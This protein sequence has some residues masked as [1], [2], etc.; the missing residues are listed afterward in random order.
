MIEFTN[1]NLLLSFLF[2]EGHFLL[3]VVGKSLV[4]ILIRLMPL[5]IAI[6][7]GFGLIMLMSIVAE[8]NAYAQWIIPSQ[9][10]GAYNQQQHIVDNNQTKILRAAGTTTTT[11]I[12]HQFVKHFPEK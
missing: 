4:L 1:I 6:V 2:S 10:N 7:T 8:N 9:L 3:G 11:T 5:A 12:V